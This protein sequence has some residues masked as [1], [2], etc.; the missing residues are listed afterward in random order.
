VKSEEQTNTRRL[1]IEQDLAGLGGG[2]KKLGRCMLTTIMRRATNEGNPTI[3]F[4]YTDPIQ[5]PSWEGRRFRLLASWPERQDLWDEYIILRQ[6]D[7]QDGDRY[8]RRAHQFYLTHREVMDA[9]AVVTNSHRYRAETLPDGSLLEASALQRCFNIIADRGLEAFQTEYQN[10]PPEESGPIESGITAHRIQTQLS[11]YERRVIPPGCT[12][13]TQGIDVRKIALHFTVKAWR[14]DATSFVIDYGVHEVY[15]TV[16]GSDEGVDLA[17]IRA[18]RDRM[19]HIDANPYQTVEGEAKTVDMTL[20][21]AGWKTEAIYHACQELRIGVMP[22][23]GFGRSAGCIKTSFSPV[24]HASKDRKPGD[25][26]FLSRRPGNVW[27]VCMDADRW[28]AWEHDRWMTPPT[29]PG[30]AMLFG[31]KSETPGRMSAD[32]KSHFSFAKHLTSEIEVETVIKGAMVRKWKTKSDTNHWFD[33]TYMA[34]VAAAMRGIGLLK[35][36]AKIKP[37]DLPSLAQLAGRAR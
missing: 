4:A 19:E 33:A 29:K 35:P 30:T 7:H 25:G 28:K 24:T 2:D 12:V 23:M 9:S 5:K 31:E 26:W 36:R 27:L 6:A 37:E 34:D 1:T 18:I 10:D 32:E 11:G 13:I 15:G 20:V 22:A 21:D 8:A 14:P 3:S 16:A 17:L